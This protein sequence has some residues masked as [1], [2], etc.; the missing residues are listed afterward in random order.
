[1]FIY[2]QLQNIN[3]NLLLNNI[4]YIHIY[5]RKNDCLYVSSIT[6]YKYKACHSEHN[7]NLIENNH[8]HNKIITE[9]DKVI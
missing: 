7:H 5:Y 8:H 3:I 1:M 2:H 4:Y 6:E 9:N